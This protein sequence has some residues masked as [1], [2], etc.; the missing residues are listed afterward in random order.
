MHALRMFI[1]LMILSSFSSLQTGSHTIDSVPYESNVVVIS[2]GEPFNNETKIE[3]PS[4]SYRV[5]LL[6]YF[7]IPVLILVFFI[8]IK[9]RQ[10]DHTVNDDP[11]NS[12]LL[13]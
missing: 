1:I 11:P 5:T 4:F 2:A 13:S 9:I 7:V 6:L 8:M 12:G 10:L 3:F